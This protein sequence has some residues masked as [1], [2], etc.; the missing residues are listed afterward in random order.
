MLRARA[1]KPST[2][3]RSYRDAPGGRA[4]PHGPAAPPPLRQR[5]RPRSC[6]RR[7]SPASQR[8]APEGRSL[9]PAPAGG[10]GSAGAPAYGGGAGDRLFERGLTR[11]ARR[12][13]ERRTHPSHQPPCSRRKASASRCAAVSCAG[14]GR[15]HPHPHWRAIGPPKGLLLRPI[16]FS[17]IS[18]CLSL[19]VSPPLPLR[20][21][22]S[23][24][25]SH[26]PSPLCLTLSFSV[27]VS[28]SFLS[29]TAPCRANGASLGRKG[30]ARRTSRRAAPVPALTEPRRGAE[31][32]LELR[33]RAQRS[34][35]APRALP[36]PGAASAG[37]GVCRAARTRA[38]DGPVLRGGPGVECRGLAQQPASPAS[39]QR[40]H[41]SAKAISRCRL[42]SNAKTVKCRCTPPGERGRCHSCCSHGQSRSVTGRNIRIR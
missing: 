24:S 23:V 5:R 36:G 18:R 1:A 25:V 17:S 10:P 12:S 19:S 20:L 26:S 27:S 21:S 34:A 39:R 16:C 2:V 41:R 35:A 9:R 6:E 32:G 40:T 8:P 28:V 4:R 7:S 3:P 31:P 11:P 38:S 37:A 14:S 22:V 29:C 33:S 42:Q 13:E 30:R 15:L